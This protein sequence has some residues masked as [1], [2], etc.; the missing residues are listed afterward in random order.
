MKTNGSIPTLVD[1][2]SNPIL[3]V[4]EKAYR[5]AEYLGSVFFFT[6]QDSSLRD[7]NLVNVRNSC[8]SPEF[9]PTFYFYPE[10]IFRILGKLK[11]SCSEPYDG[12]SQIIF[13]KCRAALSK[14]LAQIFNMSFFHGE[15]PYLWKQA[16]VTALPKTSRSCSVT[17]FRP[18][19]LTPTPVKVM[20]KILNAKILSFLKDR[21]I[22]TPEQQCFVPGASTLTNLID[23]YYDCCRA[24]NDGGSMDIVYFDFSEAFDKVYH[25]KLV[26]KLQQAGISGNLLQWLKS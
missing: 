23:H 10:D 20:E 19:S 7:D 1:G 13:K 24:V 3:S 17:N 16:I 26:T 2:Q 9:D 8:P 12:I 11:P 15:V 18:T 14:P 25:L 22:I 4:K 21:S 5:I 6:E